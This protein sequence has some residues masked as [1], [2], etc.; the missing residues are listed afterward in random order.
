MHKG[1]LRFEGTIASLRRQFAMEDLDDIFMR[2]V[3]GGGSGG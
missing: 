3:E 1:S 2:I